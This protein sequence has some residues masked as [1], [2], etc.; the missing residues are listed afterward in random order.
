[1]TRTFKDAVLHRRSYYSISNVSPVADEMIEDIIKFTVLNAPSAFNSQTSR[2]VL[3]LGENHRRLW[4]ITMDALR[5]VVSAEAFE[6]T[7]AKIESF[8][9]GYGSVLYFEEQK[10]VDSLQQQYPLYSSN[11]PIWSQHTS[12]IHQ[13][14]VWTMLEDAGFG[15]SLQHYD[16]LIEDRV[17]EEW[18]LPSSWK[19]VA[20]MPFGV[21][22]AES[23]IKS[24]EA[25]N[26]RVIIFK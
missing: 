3:L 13:F 16:E 20:Q 5:R 7:K 25:V 22:V 11:F 1:M 14:I 17:K 26:E 9:A 8:A 6:P 4:S 12:A 21:P 15:A 2:L 23:A 19:I 18:G 24:F 10:I